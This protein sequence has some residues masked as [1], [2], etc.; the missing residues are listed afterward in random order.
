MNNV[1]VRDNTATS[2]GLFVCFLSCAREAVAI[3]LSP[4][5]CT[6]RTHILLFLFQTVHQMIVDALFPKVLIPTLNSGAWM[7][8]EEGL[9][10]VW[11][12]FSF[13]L[14]PTFSLVLASVWDH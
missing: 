10:S 11:C 14:Q 3:L 1:I 2:C 9:N 7:L 8:L 12:H 5:I 4:C 6:V 13:F